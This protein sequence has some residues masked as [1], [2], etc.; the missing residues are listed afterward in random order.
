MT[1]TKSGKY[2]DFVFHSK[3]ASGL[4]SVWSVNDKGGTCLGVIGW[5]PRWR[6]YAFHPGVAVFEE[7]CLRDIAQFMQDETAKHKAAGRAQEKI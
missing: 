1:E 4:T 7:T 6:K 3:S 5:F 2:V